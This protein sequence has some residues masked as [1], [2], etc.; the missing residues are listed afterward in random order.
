MV[1]NQP[2]EDWA[3]PTS[4]EWAFMP[5]SKWERHV[6]R[7][8]KRIFRASSRGNV[9]AVRSL[10]RLLMKSWSAQCLAVRRVTQD[11]QG[12]NTAGVDGVKNLSP[13]ERIEL[14][15]AI[16]P[17][18]HKRPRPKPTRRVWIPKPGKKEMRPL[19][20]PTMEAR[21]HQALVKL[22]L[23]PEWEAKFEPNSYGF[24][25]GRSCHD[26][27]GAIF[28]GIK[29]KSKYV[30][31]ADI[32]GCFDRINHQALM[33]KLSNHPAMKR[34][35]QAWLKAGV[36][37]LGELAPTEE[38]TPQGGVISPL[39]A[40]IALHGLETAIVSA[41][42]TREKP[43]VIRYADDFVI[44]HPTEAGI[45]K[46]RQIAEAWLKDM[47]LELKPS[48]T[49]ITHTLN[50]YEGKVGFN[51]LGFNVRQF[52]QGKTHVGRKPGPNG[53]PLGFKTIITPSR[54]S[55]KRHV[56]KMAEI[57]RTMK[58]GT[59]EELIKRLNPVIGGWANYFR[60]VVA[61]ETY[62]EC[63]S[64]LYY[65]LKAWAHQRH[66][67]KAGRWVMGKYWRVD[68]GQGWKFATPEVQLK[69]HRQTLIRRHEKVT[70]TASP[71][72]G[73][74]FYWVRRLKDHPLTNNR[75]GY[76]LKVQQGKCA[77]CGLYFMDGDLIE[78][79][80]IIPRQLG[81]DNRSTNLQALHR[82]C[83]DQKTAQDG[84]NQ[85]RKR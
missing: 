15:K 23:E 74:L 27:I 51:F 81:G 5:W 48:K 63:D 78:V 59:Q 50:R 67:N 46:A 70:G 16:H 19:G 7:L 37:E 68:Q 25:P 85:A 20:M 57:V 24:R 42:V 58:A 26:A 47:G 55:V 13:T 65:I 12:K 56:V 1:S 75:L 11:N 73:K 72:D 82:H 36:I 34:V 40:N 14:A 28:N 8:Q 31:D 4:K 44:L 71:F 80:H 45:V 84:S 6:Y 18:H 33:N 43:Q 3:Q 39:L 17:R 52:A 60:T 29:A 62:A 64:H 79:D 83:H 21:A 10:Q 66:P 35:I 49:T 77:W 32:Q 38:G 53:E 22:A 69:M 54:E 2:I 9:Q 76:L 61:K 41:Y 30:L